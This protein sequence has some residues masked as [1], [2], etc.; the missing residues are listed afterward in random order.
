[1][2]LQKLSS[3]DAFVVTDLDDAPSSTGV[4]RCAPTVLTSGAADLARTT[5]YAYATLGMPR[6][7]ASAGINAP[8]DGRAAAIAAFVAEIEPLVAAGRFLPD[9]G[10]G[11]SEEDLAPL[12]PSD[13][14]TALD[15]S[16]QAGLVA[17][18]AI[19]AAE[20]ALG[21]LE[22]R[23]VAIDGFD[24]ASRP[25]V[26]AL[27]DRGAKVVAVSSTK[28]SLQDPLGIA[29]VDLA[30]GAAIIPEGAATQ[31]AVFGAPCDVLFTGS[32][33]GALDHHGAASVQAKAV[34][35]T[36]PIPVTAKA[37][38]VLQRGGAIVVPDFVVLVG[39]LLAAWG[40]PGRSPEQLGAEA[41][42]AVR[43]VLAEV[44]GH[45][46]GLFVGS[47]VRAE[48][49]LRTWREALPFGRPLAA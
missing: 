10:K 5:T 38:A 6:G 12:R 23:A 34:V 33:V 41:A 2:P 25:L 47:C 30:K 40:A 35:P 18:G 48:A 49:F 19:A 3:V 43:S 8:S 36:G 29:A 37:L 7:G 13:P 1:V 22:G 21:T 28:G 46:D 32:K 16:A 17:A 42:E 39:P 11:V 9:A 27:I 45:A 44:A 14:R 26:A 15:A 24:E 20:Q 4:V 31:V